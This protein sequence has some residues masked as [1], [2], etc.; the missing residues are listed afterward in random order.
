MG[1]ANP[2]FDGVFGYLERRKGDWFE[3]LSGAVFYKVL[4]SFSEIHIPENACLIRL[5]RRNVLTAFL[6]FKEYDLVYHCV[7]Q[8]AG[9]RH[10]PMPVRKGHKKT[11]TYTFLKKASQAI[12]AVTSFSLR[13]LYYMAGIGIAISSTTLLA[14]GVVLTMLLAGQPIA[15][16]WTSIVLSIWFLGGAIVASLGLLGVYVGKNYMQSK[17]RPR[18]IVRKMSNV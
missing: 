10:H 6:E 8:L 5:M 2:D 7:Y 12:D 18:F 4:N 17:G 15:S 1:G 16:G 14:A 3:R 11:T 13:P 9:F